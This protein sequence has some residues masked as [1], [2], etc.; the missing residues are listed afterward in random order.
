M[1][2]FD[3]D[4]LEHRLRELAFLNSGVRIDLTDQRARRE[5]RTNS[6]TKAAS[7]RFVAYLDRS[8]R[9]CTIA[10]SSSSGEQEGVRVEMRDAVERQLSREPCCASPITFRSATAARIWW[11]PRALTRVVNV[12]RRRRRRQEGEDR[13]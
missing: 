3:F 7:K 2:E 12:C 4:T 10:H 11:L 8:K 6:T 13:R 9:R 5:K 1:I